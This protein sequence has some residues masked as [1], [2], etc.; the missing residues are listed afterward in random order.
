MAAGEPGPMA[1]EK[2]TGIIA[3]LTVPVDEFQGLEG[4]PLAPPP[5][6]FLVSFNRQTSSGCDS[7][8][9]LSVFA[10]LE[11][12][13]GLAEAAVGIAKPVANKTAAAN[14]APRRNTCWLLLFISPP[15]VFLKKWLSVGSTAEIAFHFA[16]QQ[17]TF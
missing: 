5:N 9:Q 17:R 7:C 4:K 6:G 12:G 10:G 2:S 14:P 1:F 16:Q 3:I 13:D 11:I 15:V 8:A